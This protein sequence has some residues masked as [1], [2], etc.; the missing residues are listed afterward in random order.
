MSIDNQQEWLASPL[1]DYLRTQEQALFDE[2]VGDVFGFN[3]VQVGMLQMDL[4]RSSRIPFTLK[5][6]LQQGKVRCD[7]VQLPLL[8]NSIDLLLLP[9]GLD[10]SLNPQETLREAE[11]VLVAEGHLILSG[12]N[13]ISAW[14]LKRMVSRHGTYP[15]NSSFLSLLRIK[16]WLALLGFEVVSSR[17]ACYSPPFRKATWLQRFQFMDKAGGRCWPMMGGV[18]FVVAKKKVVGMR[19]IRPAWKQAKFKPGLVV[20][21][22]QKNDSQK[23]IETPRLRNGKLRNGKQ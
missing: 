15:W 5:A 23:A 6:D 2:A 1:G 18:Y 7:L 3:A 19:L 14:G 17:M 8:S 4:L 10:F 22:T 20:T 9:H 16:D 13:P 21:P 11:R 12:F